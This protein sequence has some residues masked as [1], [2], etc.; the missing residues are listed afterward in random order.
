[1][2]ISFIIPTRDRAEVLRYSLAACA[3]IP[4]R[5]IEIIVSDNSSV[6]DTPDVAA[7][8]SDSRVRYVCTPQRY[9]MRQNFEFAV[10]HARGDYIFMLGDDDAPIPSQVAYLR[11]L[12]ERY[13][14]DTLTGA[15]IGYNWPGPASPS[16]SGRLKFEYKSAYGGIAIASGE[17][18][19]AELEREG[20]FVTRHAPRIYGGAASRRIVEGLKAKTGQL[21][22]A[23]WPDAY[24]TF[25]SPSL[26][27][28]HLVVSHPFFI[29]GS[30][31]RSNGASIHRWKRNEPLRAEYE[32]FL[33]E[34][35]SDPILNIIPDTWS[36]QMGY[37]SHLESANRYAYGGSLRIDYERE[38]ER[39][40]RSLD[41]LDHSRRAE[42]ANIFAQYASERNLPQTFCDA[43]ALL[44]RCSPT[45]KAPKSSRRKRARVRSYVSINRVVLDLTAAGRTDVDAA[46][47]ACDRLLGESTAPGGLLRPI[48]WARLLL[49][50]FTS[51]KGQ[52]EA[53][54]Q[55]IPNSATAREQEAA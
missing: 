28:R 8:F 14:P 11:A 48:A 18:L 45:V 36:V 3:R 1:M 22:M 10:T 30:S 12:L 21:F 35:R 47:S 6:D 24:F 41:E 34:A 44:A 25:A 31:P 33:G 51:R 23:T 20:A 15:V 26:I 4:D 39:I 16:N 54:A 49:R 5:Q 17:Q 27:Q 32:K 43:E 9:S 7:N 53:P 38:A 40:V 29:A 52:A 13:K 50:A 42:A 19:R 37:L 2:L 46:A 55:T